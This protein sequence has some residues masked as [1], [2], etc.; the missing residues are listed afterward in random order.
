V[1]GF[2]NRREQ[3]FYQS[4]RNRE[5]GNGVILSQKKK[6]SGLFFPLPAGA[7]SRLVALTV[8]AEQQA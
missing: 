8:T 5:V 2:S 7:T 1:S 4:R 3:S 6:G